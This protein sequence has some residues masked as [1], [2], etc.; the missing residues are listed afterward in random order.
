M[1]REV[2]AELSARMQ[3][4]LS[5]LRALMEYRGNETWHVP[6]HGPDDPDSCL[7]CRIL[8]DN[9]GHPCPQD[10]LDS[11]FCEGVSEVGRP[12]T[13]VESTGGPQIQAEW[14]LGEKYP[15]LRGYWGG[16]VVTM[17]ESELLTQVFDHF[18]PEMG[19]L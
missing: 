5:S 13:L 10:A 8:E 18:F 2:R 4:V 11:F 19:V 9:F 6:E 14:D 3:G 7:T 12:L 1:S 16:E 15:V 17:H